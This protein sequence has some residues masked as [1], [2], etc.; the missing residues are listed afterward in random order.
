MPGDQV[1]DEDEDEEERGIVDQ[2]DEC[3]AAQSLSPR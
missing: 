2:A 3:R 1:V